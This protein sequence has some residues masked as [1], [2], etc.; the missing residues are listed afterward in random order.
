MKIRFCLLEQGYNASKNPQGHAQKVMEDL[1][2][3]YEKATPQSLF[4]C[5]IFE[6]C[7]NI[8]EVLP[9]CVK[10]SNNKDT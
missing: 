8:P 5:W 10:L 6:G 7:Y 1:G 2:I 9:P 3:K 4:D